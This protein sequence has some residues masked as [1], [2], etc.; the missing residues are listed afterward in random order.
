LPSELLQWGSKPK[1]AEIS[2]ADPIPVLQGVDL[3]FWALCKIWWNRQW[4]DFGADPG[5][6]LERFFT[7]RDQ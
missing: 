4:A 3:H 5:T 2:D 6:W 7:M 1:P